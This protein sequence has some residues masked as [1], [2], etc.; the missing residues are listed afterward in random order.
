MTGNGDFGDG[1]YSATRTTA[2]DTN[3]TSYSYLWI[4]LAIAAVI[5]V[6]A[7]W[8]YATRTT[9]GDNNHNDR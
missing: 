6:G 4:V 5:V 3:T 7:I 2:T 8:Y 1:A 9:N